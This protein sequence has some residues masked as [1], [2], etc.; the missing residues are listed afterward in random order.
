MFRKRKAALPPIAAAPVLVAPSAGRYR[1]RMITGIVLARRQ[2]EADAVALTLGALVPAVV[3]GMIGDAVIVAPSPDP[4]LEPVAEASGAR[5]LAPGDLPQ[6]SRVARGRWT[7]VLAAGDL[8]QGSWMSD[9]ERHLALL[10]DQAARFV[11][12]DGSMIGALAARFPD[13]RRT[14]PGLLAPVAALRAT[15]PP[16]ARRLGAHV[17]SAPH[18]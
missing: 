4:G 1:S 9:I 14:W 6:A 13:L 16:S 12:H 2:G 15:A 5:L 17:L 18:R 11:R 10:P 3:A 8:P 7:L